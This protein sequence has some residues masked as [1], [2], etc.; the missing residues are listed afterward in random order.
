VSFAI[1]NF[2]IEVA[3]CVRKYIE[4]GARLV[5]P[6]LFLDEYVQQ[7][8]RGEKLTGM[9]L[10]LANGI[11]SKVTNNNCILISIESASLHLWGQ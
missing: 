4:Q 9:W 5:L 7:A 11:S 2:H 8:F 10:V 6:I 3:N 1:L